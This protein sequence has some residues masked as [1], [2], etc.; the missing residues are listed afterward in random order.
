MSELWEL[1]HRGLSKLWSD[2]AEQ[3]PLSGRHIAHELSH[4]LFNRAR[5]ATGMLTD[6]RYPERTGTEMMRST[7]RLAWDE[8]CT[9][10]LADI[11]TGAISSTDDGGVPRPLQLWD[12]WGGANINS[13]RDVLGPAHPA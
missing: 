6:S 4:P 11:L 2:C 10:A 3:F 8:Y 12:L 13:L 1:A 7:A 9:E 5:H